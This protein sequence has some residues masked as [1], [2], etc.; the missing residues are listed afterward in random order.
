MSSQDPR[1]KAG[2][3]WGYTVRLASCLSKDAAF[4]FVGPM[5][6]GLLD[7]KVRPEFLS[8]QLALC[9]WAAAFPPVCLGLP[10]FAA[11]NALND[12][13]ETISRLMDDACHR[14]GKWG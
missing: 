6:R 9:P 8:Y 11:W 2:L 4:L 12:F 14:G 5:E 10:E 1:T 7:P 3:Y 13:R